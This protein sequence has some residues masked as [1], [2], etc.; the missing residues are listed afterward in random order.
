MG[1]TDKQ[2]Q[3][4]SDRLI[5]CMQKLQIAKEALIEITSGAQNMNTEIAEE[6]LKKIEKR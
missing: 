3:E 5:D 6:A 2:Y 4:I 1:Y